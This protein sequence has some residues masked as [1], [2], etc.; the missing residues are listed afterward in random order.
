MKF[1]LKSIAI[2]FLLIIV[3]LPQNGISQLETL[4]IR[5]TWNDIEKRCGSCDY[6]EITGEVF[7]SATLPLNVRGK[8]AFEYE[9]GAV[10]LVEID[11]PSYYSKKALSANPNIEIDFSKSRGENYLV[12]NYTPILIVDGVVK[13]VKSIE[14]TV[15]PTPV[16][17]E[18]DRAAT[19]ASSSVFASGDWYKIGIAQDGMYKLDFNFLT[20]LGIDVNSLNPNHLNVYGNHVPKLPTLNSAYHPDDVIKNAID[21]YGGGDGSFDEGD[22][23]LFYAKGPN[24]NDVSNDKI[25]ARKNTIDSLA[26]FYIHIDASDPAKRLSSISSES[27]GATHVLNSFDAFTFHELNKENLLLSGDGWL[28][29]HFDINL[30][31]SVA[32]LLTDIDPSQQVKLRTRF[33]SAAKSGSASLDVKA[34]GVVVDNLPGTIFGGDYVKA[35]VKTSEVNFNLSSAALTLEFVYNRSSPA[36]E[37]WLDF[38]QLNY[39]RKMRFSSEQ[40]LMRDFNSVGFGNIAEY[41]IANANS[42]MRVWEI[43]DP[44]NAAKVNG[45]LSGSNYSFKAGADSLRTF[46]VFSDN[47]LKTPIASGGNLGRI[48][49]QNLH[50]LTAADYLIVSHSSLLAQAER[51]A[52]L[53]RD[54]GLSVHVVELQQVYNEFSCGTADPVAIRWMAKMFYDRAAGDPSKM[55]NYLCLF[56][57]GTYDPLNRVEGNNYMVTTYNSVET[58]SAIQFQDSFTSDDF[59]GLLD[60]DEAMNFTDMLD[61]GIGRL[62]VSTPED[63]TDV[64]NKIEHYMKFGSSLFSNTTGVQC[65]DNGYSSTFGDWRNRI[66]LLADDENSGQF[67]RD[68]ESLSDTTERNHPEINVVKIYLDAY[69]QVVTSGGQRYPGVEEAINQNINKGALVF[70]Y[71]GHGGETGLAHER[72]LTVPMIQN[73]TNINNLTLFISAT[74]EFSRFDDPG[75]VSAGET[76]LKTPYGGAIGLLT[77]TRLVYITVN[78]ALVQ[79]LYTVLF[80]EENGKPLGLGEI[81]RRTKNLTLSSNNMRNFTLLGDPALRLGKPAPKIITETVNGVDITSAVDT[82]K[83]LS[84]ITVEAHVEDDFGNILSNYNGFVYPTVFDKRKIKNTL[85]QDVLS[86]VLPFDT[87]TNVIYKG[88]S[89]VKDGKFTFSF[90]VPK[91]IDYAFGFGKLSY[92]SNNGDFDNYGYDSTIIVGGVNPE[93]L[94]DNVGPDIQLFMNDD[95]FV[96]GGITNDK[97]LFIAHIKDENGVNTTGTGIGHDVTLIIDGNTAS[98]IILNNFYEADLDTY[99]SGKVNYRLSDLEEGRHEVTFKVWDVNNNSSEQT[100][101]FN[102]LKE[103]ELGISHLLNYPNPFTTNTNFYFEHNQVCNALNVKIEV[104]TISGKVVKTIQRTIQSSGFRSDGIQWDGR[105]DYGDKLARG[106]YIYRLTLETC[107]DKKA[108]KIEKLVIL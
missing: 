66:V 103:E 98:P 20:N 58:G 30:S 76:T 1:V 2:I 97:P 57:D 68:C 73:W 72:I 38:V 71:V 108:E 54:Q 35:T 49:N 55:L 42:S 40:M 37:A 21:I 9:I 96:N 65:D 8:H 14:V 10:N 23:V 70:N 79:N 45:T 83:A 106:V 60:D 32:F 107:D 22:Y 43:T 12:V 52:N 87:Q 19:F 3:V 24:V 91:D 33:A 84:K 88:K 26:Y 29:E 39:K 69:K 47:Q 44:T 90:I 4:I 104:F 56:G 99:Q 74:C 5:N 6:N 93:G 41:N 80:K 50:S 61:V 7:S 82:L 25:L 78:T 89:T 11:F 100:L 48:N 92:Y 67:V 17:D 95:N 46:A 63:A 16:L 36:S 102:V 27:G 94:D 31:Y 75:R 105:D 34:N 59:F 101:E 15:L 51:L 62:P 85:G 28:G 13:L 81:L 18:Y 53:H 64:V 77:T 86:P